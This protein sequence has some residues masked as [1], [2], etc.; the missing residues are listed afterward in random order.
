MDV[1]KKWEWMLRKSGRDTNTHKNSTKTKR[2]GPISPSD[3][4]TDL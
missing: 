2:P 1:Q 3:N 4:G